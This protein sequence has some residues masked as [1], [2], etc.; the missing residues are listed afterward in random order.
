MTNPLARIESHPHEAKRL[1]GIDYDQ[2][3]ALVSLAEKRHREKQAE[4][5]FADSQRFIGDQAYIG[6]DAITTPHKKRS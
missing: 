2:F 4:N 6:D 5:K 3:L 1:I